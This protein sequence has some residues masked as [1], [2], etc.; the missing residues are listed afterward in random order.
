MPDLKKRIARFS[1]RFRLIISFLFIVFIVLSIAGGYGLYR[2]RRNVHIITENRYVVKNKLIAGEIESDLKH[3]EANLLMISELPM[4]RQYLAEKEKA[5]H[6]GKNRHVYDDLVSGL[7]KRF[8]LLEKTFG[9][10]MQIRFIDEKGDELVR[11]DWDG[12]KANPVPPEK[13]QNKAGHRYF[14][15]TMRLTHGEI[16]ISLI[17]LNREHGVI[18]IPFKPVLRLATP[19]FGETGKRHG[20]LIV[21]L[22]SEKIIHK[23]MEHGAKSFFFAADRKGYYV[24]HDGDRSKEWGSS[25]DLGHGGSV[26]NDYPLSAG[27]IL[28]G[29][30]GAAYE[31]ELVLFYKPVWMDRE[32]GAFIVLCRVVPH[33]IVNAPVN[34]FL[35]LFAVVI[36]FSA[37]LSMGA[38]YLI[39]KL[40]TIPI[41]SMRKSARKVAG[42]DF[43][44]RVMPGG[45]P[46]IDDLAADFNKM[47]SELK[48]LYSSL[49]MEYMYLFQ[50]ANDC[51]FIQDIEGRILTANDNASKRLG[52]TSE[53]LTGM[54]MRE[55]Y[56]SEEAQ[57]IESKIGSLRENASV[58][59]ES[60][61]RR[62]DGSIVPVEIS[63][64]FVDYRGR[65]VIQSHVR[66]ISERKKAEAEITRIHS[67]LGAQ[68]S[69][70][71][72]LAKNIELD[73]LLETTLESIMQSFEAEAGGIYLLDRDG[74]ML[75]LRKYKGLSEN[76]HNAV[77]RMKVGE[78]ITGRAVAEMAPVL[79]ELPDYKYA[80]VVDILKK[81]DLKSL[82][83]VPVF[84]RGK[85]YGALTLAS[86][87]EY[88]FSENDIKLLLSVCAQVAVGIE[89]S[90][91]YEQVLQQKQQVEMVLESIAD[92]VLS[93]GIENVITTWSRGAENITGFS[94]SEVIGRHCKEILSHVGE[95]GQ[96][97]CDT[98]NCLACRILTTQK[99]II[100]EHVF[101]HHKDGRL[102][103][104]SV[105]AA[106]IKNR[107]GSTVG[108]VEV[109][110][111][112]TKEM[113]LIES[114]KSADKAKSAFI[115]NMSHELRTPLS[116]II[117]FA[118]ILGE[119]HFG[120]LN[121]K[122]TVFVDDIKV[123][124]K[125]LLSLINDILDISKIEAGKMDLELSNIRLTDLFDRGVVMIRGKALKDGVKIDV[126]L[127]G[128]LRNTGLVADERM[129]KQVIFNL[130]SNAVKFTPRNGAVALSARI[131]P[132]TAAGGTED[133]QLIEISVSDTGEGIEPEN[134]EKIFDE[135]FQVKSEIKGK[136]PG[137][138]LGLPISRRL[139]EL[140]GGKIWAESGGKG[141]GSTFKIL[142]PLKYGA[143][144]SRQP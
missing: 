63:A 93:M 21:N 19:V 69:I 99:P 75:D 141:R 132:E 107:S 142:M 96:T 56:I 20:I 34:R 72:A 22:Y 119:R 70:A 25:E 79:I 38:G 28:S 40:I 137:T 135:F 6:G 10:Y 9:Y 36:L 74:K 122:Q 81:Q 143:K 37:A 98:D 51:I 133:L 121:E 95:N 14:I 109:F 103:P 91:L 111:D 106:P 129:L 4:F 113:Q 104:V 18:D 90:Y 33:S 126:D 54:Q 41:E 35:F 2:E 31:G 124:S 125:H 61:Y 89:N 64:T 42:G 115:S 55:I 102:I 45:Y 8:G 84:S 118:D 73:K 97:M 78:G 123:S 52:Y 139:V 77:K 82:V 27:A 1:L 26:L 5:G 53:E 87:K 120:T 105:T 58:V 11:V 60:R 7:Q 130:L 71:S 65:K 68:Y 88:R 24:H 30:E 144:Q 23:S 3:I 39:S 67:E 13:L 29:N 116:A 128:D 50:K 86:K 134:R 100:S 17:N 59:F 76:F 127:P 117:G 44:T 43:D 110:R 114:I 32:G 138:G 140:H 12:K 108:I 66:D 94:G 47:A 46:E 49:Q 62:K 15:E 131:V 92:G 57:N 48:K 80:P 16:Y 136:T 83:S 112:V 85:V 101:A